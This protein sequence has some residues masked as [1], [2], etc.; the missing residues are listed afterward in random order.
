MN[1]RRRVNST[2]MPHEDL[3]VTIAAD[4]HVGRVEEKQQ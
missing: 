1:A 3:S 4:E 2:V